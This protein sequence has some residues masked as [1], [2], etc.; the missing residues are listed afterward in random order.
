MGGGVEE[1]GEEV[2]EGL[3]AVEGAGF[4]PEELGG[5]LFEVFVGGAVV[6]RDVEGKDL[7]GE[8]GD[9]KPAGIILDG[10]AEIGAG[11]LPLPTGADG[12]DEGIHGEVPHDENEGGNQGHEED[13]QACEGLD[14]LSEENIGEGPSD[15]GHAEVGEMDH[16]RDTE[17]AGSHYLIIGEVAIGKTGFK[18]EGL[19]EVAD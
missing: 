7:E 18:A 4:E 13:A 9:E 17:N 1:G 2:E 15:I 8:I 11:C 12:R 16:E 5:A 14:E 19:K 3:D 10:D 6:A